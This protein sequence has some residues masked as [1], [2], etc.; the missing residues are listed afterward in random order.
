MTARW[1]ESEC[2]HEDTDEIA[3]L[4]DDA[5]IARLCNDCG[6]QVEQAAS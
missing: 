6:A 2:L 3:T 1:P 4:G 5:P